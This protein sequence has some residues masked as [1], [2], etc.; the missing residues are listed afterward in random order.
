MILFAVVPL[1]LLLG[2]LI[3]VV[4][5]MKAKKQRPL[6]AL[7][8][9]NALVPMLVLSNGQSLIYDN[10]RLFMATFIFV[11]ALAGIG[12]DWALGATQ[13]WLKTSG[14]VSLTR[15]ALAVT[16]LLVFGL[17]LILAIPYYPH[18]LSYYSEAIGGL[19]GATKLGLETTYWCETYSA[20]LDYINSNARKGDSVWVDWWSHDVMVYYQLQGRLRHDV[21]IATPPGGSSMLDDNALLREN[22]F[23][24]ADI[25]VVQYRQTSL[26]GDSAESPILD[27][28]ADR[29]PGL[30]VSHRGILLMEVY[31]Q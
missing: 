29:E 13:N 28:L 12:V 4:R 10:E 14:R 30:R 2:C 15:P 8:V 3:G 9:F 27:W 21:W 24:E 16:L 17:H 23:Y 31:Q 1:I 25:I 7:F 18:W 19:P 20:A 22:T 26:F 11:A 6:G 5:S